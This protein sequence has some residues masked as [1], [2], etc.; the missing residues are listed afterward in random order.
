MLV[1][2]GS[3]R[4]P[5]S[6]RAPVSGWHGATCTARDREPAPGIDAITHVTSGVEGNSDVGVGSTVQ[7]SSD[8]GG[9]S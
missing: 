9:R 7:G 5:R 8:V 1:R 2:T 6:T 3:L 4:A